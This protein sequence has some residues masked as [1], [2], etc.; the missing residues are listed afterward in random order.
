SSPLIAVHRRGVPPQDNFLRTGPP[1]G[2][3]RPGRRRRPRHVLDA[4]RHPTTPCRYLRRTE[5]QARDDARAAQLPCAATA[6]LGGCKTCS[7]SHVTYVCPST[8]E[9]M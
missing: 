6:S 1:P 4:E 7:R 2:P 8:N 5:F 9:F 3:D